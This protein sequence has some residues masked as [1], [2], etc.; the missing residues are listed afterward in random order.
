M[1]LNVTGVKHLG[2]YGAAIAY[3]CSMLVV[4]HEPCLSS[5]TEV[6]S[7][8]NRFGRPSGHAVLK[9]SDTNLVLVL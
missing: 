1:F 9:K 6:I 8:E 3:C 2:E 7:E 5:L 4:R